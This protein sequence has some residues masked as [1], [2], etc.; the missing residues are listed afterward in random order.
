MLKSFLYTFILTIPFLSLFGDD[1]SDAKNIGSMAGQQAI[2]KYGSKSNINANMSV[3]LQGQTLMTTVDGSG[4]FSA[5]IESCSENNKGIKIVFSPSGDGTLN[6][7]I[8]QDLNATGSYNYS[9]NFSGIE[10]VCSGGYKS[11]DGKYYKYLFS[12]SSKRISPVEFLKSDLSG[13]FCITNSC[14]YGGF[15]KNLADKIAGDLIGVIGSSGIGNYRVGINEYDSQSRTYYLYVQNDTN[16]KSSNLGNDYTNVNPSSYY[17][18]QQIPPINLTD[19]EAKDGKK[20]DSL[21]YVTSNH[22]NTGINSIKGGSQHNI[23]MKDIQTCKIIKSPIIDKNSIKIE[24]KD[25]CNVDSSCKLDREEICDNSG[26][27]CIDK[28]LNG[29]DTEYNIP[30][31]CQDYGDFQLCADGDSISKI[32]NQKASS[33]V[34][35]SSGDSYFYIKRSYDCGNSTIEYNA[36]K[37]N[38]TFDSVSKSGADLVYTDFDGVSR[39]IKLEEFENCQIRHCRVKIST[40]HTSVYTDETSN[41]STKDGVSTIDYDFRQCNMLASG[42]YSCPTEANETILEACSCNLSM[43]AATMTIGYASAVEEAVKDFTC[44]TK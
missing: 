21:Y 19:V 23:T 10:N 39:N 35:S 28:V 4:S 26:R 1:K 38:Q 6:I 34:S 44:S 37:S 30:T 8:N 27:N 24:T 41:V 29:Q 20:S 5:K 32:Q 31:Q 33:I 22:S 13:C 11:I 17:S 16:C 14:R 9:T 25:S 40:K 36:S 7:Q 42:S 3:P 15:N 12:S 2:S 43:D 18:S